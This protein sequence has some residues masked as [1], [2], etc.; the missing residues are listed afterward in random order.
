MP[1][2][3]LSTLWHV[4]EA[5]IVLAVA[6]VVAHFFPE[7]RDAAALAAVAALSALA[8]GLRS[9][10]APVPDYVNDPPQG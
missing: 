9:S 6:L 10:D 2:W 8:K 3:L 7:H 1:T 4:G 5:V